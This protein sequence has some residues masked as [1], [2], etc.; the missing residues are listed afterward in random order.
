MEKPKNNFKI[1][2]ERRA[3]MILPNTLTLIGVCIGLSSIKFA[4]D[5]KFELSIIAILFAA[6]F[7]ALDGRVARLIKGTSLVGKE[8]DSLADVISFGVAP[9][10]IMYFWILNNLG[11]FGWLLCLIYVVCVAL[12]LARFNVNT[13]EEPSWKDNFFEGIPSPAG[14]ILILMPLV[15]SLSELN[16]I[17]I[18]YNIVVPTFFV[19]ISFLL[20]SKVPTYSFKKIVIPRRM[21]IFVLFG[22]VLFF[23]LLLIYTFKVL[24]L[25][26]LIYICLIPI[27][28][29][30][31]RKI[32]KEKN[33]LDEQNDNEDIEDIL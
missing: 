31:Y 7:D 18:N 30:S 26:G 19:I 6:M 21:T 22:I 12:R 24:V 20:I 16:I 11:K 9:A 25:G 3:R 14:G 17:D 10:F 13:S 2:S 32:H 27:G 28:Y 15:F 29:F 8:L 1:V 5:S 4:L 23:G 33:L